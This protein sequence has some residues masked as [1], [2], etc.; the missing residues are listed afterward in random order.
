MKKISGNIKY[1]HY[2]H[3][4]FSFMSMCIYQNIKLYTLNTDSILLHQ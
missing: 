3:C 1:I 4:T 2:L